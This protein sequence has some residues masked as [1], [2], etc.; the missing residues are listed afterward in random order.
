M[1]VT[2]I[3][4]CVVVDTNYQGLSQRCRP[5]RDLTVVFKSI[6]CYISVKMEQK[7]ILTK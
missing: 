2:K 6:V 1:Y 3:S 7:C 5:S 4:E